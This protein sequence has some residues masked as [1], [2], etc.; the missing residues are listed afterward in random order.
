MNKTFGSVGALLL[1]GSASGAFAQPVNLPVRPAYSF[2]ASSGPA[3]GPANVRL[4]ESPIFATPYLGLGVGYDDNL[5]LSSSNER[6]TTYYVVSPGVRLDARDANKVFALSYQG[7]IGRYGQSEEDNY[8][9]HAVRGSFDMAFGY[10]AFLRLN[11]DYIRGHDPRGSTDRAISA[12]PD[13]YRLSQP[14]V[15]FAYG[16]PGADG[17]VEVYYSDATKRYTNNRSTTIGSD[18]DTQEYGAAFYWRIMPRTY[19]I[20]EGRQTDLSYKSPTSPFSG[21]EQRFLAGITWE[22]TA[23]TTGTIKVG[24]LRK[25]FDSGL[26]AYDGTAWE[27]IITW[28]PRTYSRFDFYSGR[29]P[30]ESTGLGT[31]ILSEAT[32]AVWHHAWNSLFTTEASVRFQKD[33]YQGFSRND[34]IT[35]V[36]VRAGYRFRRWLTLGAEYTF[37]TRDSST[38]G[39]D[40]DKNLFLLTATITM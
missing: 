15:T 20:V 40:Y 38:P 1:I 17:R 32:G 31:F 9:D 13:K 37:T 18:R 7:T 5:L 6:G 21:E 23:A 22:A 24:Q 27:G 36:G 10:R 28:S 2:P 12:R 4:G 25:K 11:A 30:T 3:S 14:G 8:V 34:D 19:A 16:A 26:P 33:D 39:F 35:S 29:Y